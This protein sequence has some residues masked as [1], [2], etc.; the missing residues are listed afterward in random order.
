M[1]SLTSAV[2]YGLRYT[3]RSGSDKVSPLMRPLAAIGFIDTSPFQRSTPPF[4]VLALKVYGPLS[5]GSVL[6]LSSLRS[7]GVSALL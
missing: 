1:P 6:K 2:V 7:I 4:T 3:A 5:C